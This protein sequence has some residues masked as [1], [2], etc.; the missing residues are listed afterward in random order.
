MLGWSESPKQPGPLCMLERPKCSTTT[1][2]DHVRLFTLMGVHCEK[3]HPADPRLSLD[4]SLRRGSFTPKN[5]V[6]LRD[7]QTGARVNSSHA[8]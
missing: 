2:S 1:G 5:I 7:W 8:V 6:I 3:S 4:G